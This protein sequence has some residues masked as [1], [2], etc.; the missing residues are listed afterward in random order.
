MMSNEPEVIEGAWSGRLVVM[1]FPDA[2]KAPAWYDSPEY[3]DVRKI[4]WAYSTTNMA[5]VPRSS[6][7]HSRS[8]RS[9]G[10][11]PC[12]NIWSVEA[13]LVDHSPSLYLLGQAVTVHEFLAAAE[14]HRP[15]KEQRRLKSAASQAT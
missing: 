8:L 11:D 12:G 6:R 9:P 3:H 2:E 5:L 14:V 4:R 10:S 13:L 1:T 7:Q 15:L